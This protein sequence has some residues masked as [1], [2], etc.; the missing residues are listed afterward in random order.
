MSP[1]VLVIVMVVAVLAAALVATT[2]VRR[3]RRRLAEEAEAAAAAAIPLMTEQDI[4]YR[5]GLEE[6]PPQ[7]EWDPLTPGVAPAVQAAAALPVERPGGVPA[8]LRVAA[9]PVAAVSV[10][11]VAPEP[12][13]PVSRRYR[14]WR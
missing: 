8:P 10:K 14:L 4:A 6:R 3:R 13:A 11:A 12:P 2:F 5:I 9:T 7:P 1:I